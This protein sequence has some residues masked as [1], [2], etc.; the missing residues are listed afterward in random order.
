MSYDFAKMSSQVF[1]FVDLIAKKKLKMWLYGDGVHR[2]L[3][4]CRYIG[5]QEAGLNIG[6]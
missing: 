2:S 6:P 1:Y 5:A 3:P 4:S